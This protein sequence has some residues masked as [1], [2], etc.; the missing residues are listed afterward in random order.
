MHELTRIPRREGLAASPW[1]TTG[2]ESF[3]LR[4]GKLD[5]GYS[6]FYRCANFDPNSRRCLRY[7]D[8]PQVCRDHPRYGSDH[9]EPAAALP[10][11]CSYRAEQGLPVEPQPDWQHVDLGVKP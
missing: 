8:R 6:T 7:D 4:D 10:A 2:K 3:A 9:V 5:A 11:W 1:L